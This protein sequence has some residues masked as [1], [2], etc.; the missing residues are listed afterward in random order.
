MTAM[1][2]HFDA[3]GTLHLVLYLVFLTS[4]VGLNDDI[5]VYFGS[6]FPWLETG[7]ITKQVEFFKC[8]FWAKSETVRN[9]EN[10]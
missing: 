5:C 4:N 3:D 2:P 8:A 10:H 7:V 6:L 1:I 9:I